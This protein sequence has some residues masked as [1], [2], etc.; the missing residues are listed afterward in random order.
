MPS[1]IQQ[2]AEV[3]LP[4]QVELFASPLHV[5][6]QDCPSVARGPSNAPVEDPRVQ[7]PALQVA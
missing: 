2:E 1:L 3:P 4:L 5:L 7:M 6:P